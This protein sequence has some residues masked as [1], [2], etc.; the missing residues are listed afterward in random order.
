MARVAR[1][2]LAADY[3]VGVT[4]ITGS[5]PVEDKPPGTITSP[6]TTEPSASPSYTITRRI[7]NKRRAVTSALFLLR[8]TLLAADS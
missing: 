5:E 2:N 3:G 1:Q 6:S 7:A 8:R 4:G